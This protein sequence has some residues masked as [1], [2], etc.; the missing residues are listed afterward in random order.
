MKLQTCLHTAGS[1]LFQFPLSLMLNLQRCQQYSQ[2]KLNH[3]QQKPRWK[4]ISRTIKRY[5]PAIH[6]SN[7]DG[8]NG[9]RSVCSPSIQNQ[10]YRPTA[11]TCRRAVWRIPL[12][13]I[14]RAHLSAHVPEPFQSSL[15][16]NQ[17][18]ATTYWLYGAY[19]VR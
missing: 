7:F 11:A 8:E 14:R 13:Y 16:D 18:H 2:T 9:I 1:G 10:S 15:K 4:K 19:R 6:F 17:P 5:S 12:C 3:W